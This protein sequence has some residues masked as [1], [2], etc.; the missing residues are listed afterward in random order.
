VRD[1]VIVSHIE[2]NLRDDY[3]QISSRHMQ[4]RLQDNNYSWHFESSIVVAPREPDQYDSHLP[5]S[6]Q[7][8]RKA[9]EKVSRA[10]DTSP[11]RPAA[12]GGEKRE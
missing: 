7:A 4:E 3:H 10:L 8:L 5:E 9:N 6:A 1:P 12:R 2:N 11:Q